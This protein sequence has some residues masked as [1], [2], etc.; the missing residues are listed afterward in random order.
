MHRA[1]AAFLL[2]AATSIAASSFIGDLNTIKAHA[3]T[4]PANG[5]VNPYGVAVVPSSIGDLKSRH[6][7]VS[8]FNDSGNTQGTGTTIVGLSRG[9]QREVV[10]SDQRRELP[11]GSRSDDGACRAALRLCDRWQP[12]N[13]PRRP[14]YGCPERTRL[15]DGAEQLRPSGENV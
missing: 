5:D 6:V 3:S 8:N 14:Q 7:L 10:R 2:S 4:I 13:L 11:R 15:P 1:L 12:A 9:R